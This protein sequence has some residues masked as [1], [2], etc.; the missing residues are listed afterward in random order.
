MAITERKTPIPAAQT[1]SHRFDEGKAPLFPLIIGYGNPARGD[2]ALGP[3][4][5]ERI[6]E[7]RE[8][9]EVLSCLQLQPELVFDL[10]DRPLV[11]FIDAGLATPPPF[12]LNRVKAVAAFDSSSH[13]LTPGVLLAIYEAVLQLPPPPS[14]LLS[15]RGEHF[16]LGEA[17][18]TEATHRLEAAHRFLLQWLESEKPLP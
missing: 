16:R 14:F 8:D 7:E 10:K 12:L 15:I 5:S 17:L 18:S 4:L 9:C 6:A 13:T 2:D 1:R 11:L 3:L